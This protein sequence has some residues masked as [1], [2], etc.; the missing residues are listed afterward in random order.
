MYTHRGAY[1]NA[2]G[3]LLHSRLT[4]DCGLPLDPADVPLQRLVPDLGRDRPSAPP[5][6]ACAGSI[7]RVV[8]ELIER[9][10]VTHFNGAPTVLI[11]LVNHPLRQDGELRGRLTVTTGGAPPSPTIIA[12]MRGARRRPRPRLRADRD[13]RA[14]HRLRG[15]TG[16]VQPA[17]GGAGAAQGAPGRAVRHRRRRCAWSTTI[18]ATCRPTAR[19]WARS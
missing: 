9:E 8:W 19:R 6:S 12:Q 13:L 7:P 2:L 14:E 18:C 15:A 4:S 11:A 16:V 1:L 17:R 10:G 5:T 3:E